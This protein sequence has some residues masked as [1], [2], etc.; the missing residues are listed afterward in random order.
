MTSWL[1][2]VLTPDRRWISTI[3]MRYLSLF[4][5]IEAATVAW[6]PLGWT[7]V[8]VSEI[9]P[10]ACRILAHHYPSVL[11]LGD[12]EKITDEQ[13]AALGHLDIVIGGSPCQGLSSAGKRKGLSDDRSGLFREQMRIFNAARRLC[14]ARFL[15]WEN[16]PGAFS[17]NAGADFAE[18]VGA[19]AGARIAVPSGGWRNEGVVLG[20]DGLVEWS[21]LDAR[22]FGLAQ[23]RQRLFTLLDTGDW[24]SRPPVLLEPDA[25]R[26]ASGPSFPEEHCSAAVAQGRF[27]APIGGGRQSPVET[28]GTAEASRAPAGG[29]RGPVRNQRLTV[30]S[31]EPARLHPPGLAIAIHAHC[32]GRA[33]D[34]G[35]QSKFHLDDNTAYTVD[36][37][38]NCQAVAFVPNDGRSDFEVRRLTPVEQ[39]TLQ[40]FPAGYTAVAVDS[41]AEKRVSKN[42]AE[43]RWRANGDA[44]DL[45]MS[46]SDRYSAIGNSFPVPVIRWIGK[47]LDRALGLAVRQAA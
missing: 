47:S 24:S 33:D 25:M 21:V 35:P 1:E 11:N 39:E 28:F 46:D 9:R 3:K 31:K 43:T 34:A 37:R 45:L 40:G 44:W 4:S 12:V 19:M 13:I 23:R 41:R 20:A 6:K 14:G 17:S 18:V 32:L 26:G 2:A 27:A 36:A 16:V 7:C 29:V 8:A 15:L 42:N 5:G 30:G 10:S 38:S 22:W